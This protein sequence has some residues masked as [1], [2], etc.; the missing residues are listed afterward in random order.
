M[1]AFVKHFALNDQ[2]THRDH[3][4]LITW[5]NEQTIREVY[6]KPFEMTIVDNYSEVSYNKPIYDDEMNITSYTYETTTLPSTFGIMTSFN[7][8]GSTWAGGDYRLITKILREEW[9][10]NGFVLTDYEVRS[11]M[12][13]EQALAAGGDAKLTTVD[14]GDFSLKD[15][16]EYHKYAYD[17]AHHILYTVVNSS[18]MNGFIHGV[19]FVNGFA[20]YK[21]M[22]IVADV[23]LLASISLVSVKLG[24][25]LYKLKK[26]EEY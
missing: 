14:W 23:I 12:F 21:I 25:K 11:Y 2:E 18:G 15:N 19:K 3:L 17:A 20:Y 1:Y 8:I 22:L 7:R 16:P 13:T 26:E 5:S 9:G 6:L 24:K 4:G 10:Y